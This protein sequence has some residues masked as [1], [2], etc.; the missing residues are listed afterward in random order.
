MPQRSLASAV[1]ATLGLVMFHLKSGPFDLFYFFPDVFSA[2]FKKSTP[3]K[4]NCKMITKAVQFRMSRS[5]MR[6]PSFMIH[7]YDEQR[8][9]SE[10]H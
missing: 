3:E 1:V 9:S 10:D 8:L 2:S 5:S 4:R 7:R 6:S